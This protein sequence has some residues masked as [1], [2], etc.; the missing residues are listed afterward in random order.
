MNVAFMVYFIFLIGILAGCIV[1]T[2]KSKTE[3]SF[4]ISIM[5]A[6]AICTVS[7]YSTSLRAPRMHTGLLMLG[8]Y[9]ASFY[10]LVILMFNYAVL[11]TE[12][13]LPVKYAGGIAIVFG[14]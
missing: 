13:K 2:R 7:F 14:I 9:Y 3:L 8:L 12:Y 4:S 5:L 10:W 6:M 1:I 11:L